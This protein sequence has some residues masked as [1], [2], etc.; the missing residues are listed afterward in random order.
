MSL[1]QIPTACERIRTSSGPIDGCSSS[2][3][4]ASPGPLRSR[5]FMDA[6][7]SDFIR[8]CSQTYKGRCWHLSVSPTLLRSYPAGQVRRKEKHPPLPSAPPP[9]LLFELV[10][11]K[12]AGVDHTRA[13]CFGAHV[14]GVFALAQFALFGFNKFA[15]ESMIERFPVVEYQ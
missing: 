12:F 4:T 15:R 2:V 3:T 1:P 13:V 7:L 8:M 10:H 9:P 11:S 5:A 14:I 6:P